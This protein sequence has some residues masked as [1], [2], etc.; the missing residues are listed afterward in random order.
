MII[1]VTDR[2]SAVRYLVEL[3][4][5]PEPWDNGPFRSVQ[6]DDQVVVN[7]AAPPVEIQPQHYAFLVTDEH[8][9]RI[10]ARFDIDGTPYAADPPGTRPQQVGAVNPDGTGRRLYFQGPSGHMLEVLT[11]RYNAIPDGS[12]PTAHA[13]R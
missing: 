13:R 7:V 6:L 8:F 10:R 3:L 4:E 12:R 2:D 11:A 5:L 9:D 1:P